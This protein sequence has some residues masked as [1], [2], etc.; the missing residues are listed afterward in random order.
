MIAVRQLLDRDRVVEIAR[1]LAVDRDGP[2]RAEV[3]APLEVLLFDGAAQPRGLRHCLGAVLVG[4]AEL[5]DDDL[6]VDT[7][8]LDV[9]EDLEDAAEGA[10]RRRRPARDLGHDH[11]PGLRVLALLVGDH[12]VH[13]QA[14]VE[15]DEIP[16]AGVVDFEAADN[17][18]G[19]ALEDADDP[20]FGPV[21]PPLFD[22]RDHTVA[23]HRLVQVGAGDENVAGHP[24]QRLVRDD[25]PEAAGVRLDA[26]DDEVHP[27]R[28]A[29]MIAPRL[30][31]M[32][33]LD[34]PLEQAV[35]GGPLLAG[36]LQP[37]QELPGGRRVLD[38]VTDGGQQL[39]TIQHASLYL[40][41]RCAA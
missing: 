24:L 10:A 34:Q 7:G 9:A 38:L 27:I 21:L 16:C 13:D 23:V 31:Q 12:H 26:P 18:L 29:V 14:A 41:N 19:P 15:R 33:G 40:P 30:N 2:D 11:V 36:D 5:A 28:Q 8:L 37:R 25:E 32:T 17:R 6:G 39:F 35:D 4:D 20:S 22:P 1:V 3:G